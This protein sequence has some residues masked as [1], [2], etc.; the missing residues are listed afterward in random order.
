MK[1]AIAWILCL[2]L[3]VSAVGCS[4]E[5]EKKT[6]KE[7]VRLGGLTG[8]TTM[9]MV[10]L[11]E[12]NEAGKTVNSYEFTLAGSAD[13]LTPLFIQGELDIISVP[14]NLGSV[15]YNKT[16]VEVQM[17]CVNT[18][19]VLYILE[20][21]D[22]SVQSIE[23]LKG[24]TLYATGK[25]ST[26]EY[27]LAY[28][29]ERKGLKLGE[30]V[31][32]EWKSEPGEIVSQLAAMDNALCMLP[33]PY[34][35]VAMSKVEGLEMRLDLTEEWDKAGTGTQLIT[36][37]VFVRKEFAESHPEAVAAFMEEFASSVEYVNEN[38]GESA[39]LVEKYIHVKSGVAEQ[40]IPYCHIVCIKG[41]EMAD[42]TQAFLTILLGQKPEAVGGALPNG[43]FYY[44]N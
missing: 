35:T 29:L 40:A 30:D 44:G 14:V 32:V 5:E 13:E 18:L 22:N 38:V 39:Q 27:T 21:G 33:Q 9:G 19:G 20:K 37:G 4:K 8:P 11:L 3:A 25:G 43:D 28:L 23:D 34:V 26:P 24:K 10:K 2:L 42:S 6:E 16:N 36:S 31:Q 7:A 1:R 12:E 15:L 17:L 41:E